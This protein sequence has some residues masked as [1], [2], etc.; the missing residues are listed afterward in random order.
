M[1]RTPFR[2]AASPVPTRKNAWDRIDK[3]Y[4]IKG[5]TISY[6]VDSKVNTPDDECKNKDDCKSKDDSVQ[7]FQHFIMSGRPKKDTF[8][9]SPTPDVARSEPKTSG[10]R[11]K[12]NITK[13]KIPVLK[14]KY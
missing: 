6:K 12:I 4:I 10:Q 11:S 3:K 9:K 14:K 2:R 5:R 7:I 1:L 8:R 13:S